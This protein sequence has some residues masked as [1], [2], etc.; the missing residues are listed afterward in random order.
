MSI[1]SVLPSIQLIL[2]C[3]LLLL[4]SIFPSI[5]VFSSKSTRHIRWPKYWSFSIS[6]SIDVQDWFPLG[7]T[8][9]SPCCPRDSQEPSPAPQFESITFGTQLLYGPVLTS[10]H[11]YWKTT[12]LAVQTFVSKAMSLFFNMLSRFVIAFLPRSKCLLI[13]WLQS[14]STVILEP[15]NIKSATVSII[16]PSICHY[17]MGLHTMIF[18]FWMLSFKPAFS[19]SSLT[20]I[21]RL[22][23]SSSLSDTRVV[24]SAY[25]RLLRMFHYYVFGGI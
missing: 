14:P 6:A 13:S 21:K 20:F 10:T 17:V 19:F 2:C 9:W 4:L 25:L 23:S 3:S 12:A 7:L 11:D 24:S 16:S 15:K 5:R 22:F 1:E 8:V 18:V